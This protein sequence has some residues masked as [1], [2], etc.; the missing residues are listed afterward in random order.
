MTTMTS[1]LTISRLKTIFGAAALFAFLTPGLALGQTWTQDGPQ[2]RL[3]TAV[4][5]DSAIDQM[6]VFGGLSATVPLNDVWSV[7][8]VVAAGQQVTT[9]PYHWIQV[10]PTGT[11]PAAR[12]GMGSAYDATSNRMIIFGGGASSTSCF[13]DLWLLE[14]ANQSGGT[15]SWVQSTTSGTPPSAR[16]NFVAQYDSSSNSLIVFGGYNC[17]SGYLSDVWVLSNAN[18]NSGT[19]TWTKLSPSGVGPTARENASAIY[20]STNHVLTLYAGDAGGAGLSDVWSLSNAN[21]AGTSVWTHISPT[22]TAPVART[23]QT[24]VYDSVNNRMIMYGGVTTLSGTVPLGDTWVLTFANDLGGTPAWISEK[25]TGTAPTLKFHSGFYNSPYNN[26][27]V[28]GGQN[29][30][31]GSPTND[32]AF[33]LTVANDL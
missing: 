11:A 30:I 1:R 26:M 10:F 13:N 24:S 32:R 14:D 3:H 4:V 23:G 27:V 7:P 9:S 29:Q 31:T 5:Y 6:I 33:V 28:F 18:G 12:Y 8:S 19:S 25:V 2:A 22:G 15:P 16:E 20:D 21:G 17:A